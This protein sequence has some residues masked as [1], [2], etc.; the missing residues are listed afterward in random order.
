M[1]IFDY[2]RAAHLNDSKHLDFHSDTYSLQISQFRKWFWIF[3]CFWKSFRKFNFDWWYFHE[4]TLF[5]FACAD[6]IME[7]KKKRKT[8]LFSVSA[9]PIE[10]WFG[11]VNFWW[12]NKRKRKLGEVWFSCANLLIDGPSLDLKTMENMLTS[13][14]HRK[15]EISLSNRNGNSRYSCIW[16][17]LKNATKWSFSL[18]LGFLVKKASS[19]IAKYQ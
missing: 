17:Q 9:V 2:L 4:S 7:K 1:K 13:K 8:N 16:M 10:C 3:V 12:Q 18:Y 15:T 6:E 14:S 11:G 19:G 5:T